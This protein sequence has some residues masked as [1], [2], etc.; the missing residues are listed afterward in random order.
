[1]QRS[2]HS[3]SL[4]EKALNNR[5]K[6]LE[7]FDKIQYFQEFNASQLADLIHQHRAS[8]SQGEKFAKELVKRIAKNIAE[9]DLEKLAKICHIVS[10]YDVNQELNTSLLISLFNNEKIC[11][12]L[13][14]EIIARTNCRILFRIHVFITRL[15]Q[16]DR[17]IQWLTQIAEL[18]SDVCQILIENFDFVENCDQISSLII[19]YIIENQQLELLDS[20]AITQEH[21]NSI[22]TFKL[23]EQLSCEATTIELLFHE[24]I[25]AGFTIELDQEYGQH[26][27]RKSSCK[28]LL[29][30]FIN[31]PKF[32]ELLIA[33]LNSLG[34]DHSLAAIIPE[35]YFALANLEEHRPDFLEQVVNKTST[36]VDVFKNNHCIERIEP[37][38]ISAIIKH[39][40]HDLEFIAKVLTDRD[41]AV[42][43][44]ELVFNTLLDEVNKRE[45]L[46]N[47]AYD[48]QLT[49]VLLSDPMYFNLLEPLE[50]SDLLLKNIKYL[51]RTLLSSATT[52]EGEFSFENSM[53]DILRNLQVRFN[54]PPEQRLFLLLALV[55]PELASIISKQKPL[56]Y[57]NL[58]HSDVSEILAKYADNYELQQEFFENYLENNSANL[59]PTAL[60]FITK[61]SALL[62]EWLQHKAI[63]DFFNST[64]SKVYNSAYYLLRINSAFKS[65]P[66]LQQLIL[67][68]HKHNC[69][70][71]GILENLIEIKEQDELS[72]YIELLAKLNLD[73]RKLASF[74]FNLAMNIFKE[75]KLYSLLDLEQMVHL[76]LQYQDNERFSLLVLRIFTAIKIMHKISLN[77]L[78][79]NET[80]PSLNQFVD[81]QHQQAAKSI[82]DLLS[83]EARFHL[84]SQKMVLL[85]SAKYD[86]E[87]AKLTFANND[88]FKQL[89][90]LDILKI[91]FAHMNTPQFTDLRRHLSG[92]NLSVRTLAKANE[93]TAN[94]I[95]QRE[96]TDLRR[97]FFTNQEQL[98]ELY[99]SQGKDF[100]LKYRSARY[101]A[102]NLLTEAERLN[103]CI[104]SIIKFQHSGI[105]KVELIDILLDMH[106]DTLQVALTN[107]GMAKIILDNFD[108]FVKENLVNT[109]DFEN[110]AR[111]H[112]DELA[113]KYIKKS[114]WQSFSVADYI[115]ERLSATWNDLGFRAGNTVSSI[116]DEVSSLSFATPVSAADLNFIHNYDSF[117]NSKPEVQIR[118]IIKF[119]NEGN[120]LTFFGYYA[121]LLRPRIKQYLINDRE[122]AK[123]LF[124]ECKLLTDWVD[125]N[126]HPFLLQSD[127]IEIAERHGPEFIRHHLATIIYPSNDDLNRTNQPDQAIIDSFL[128]KLKTTV[129]FSGDEIIDDVICYR[130][131]RVF[132]KEYFKFLAAVDRP[133]GK[134]ILRVN[135]FGRSSQYLHSIRKFFNM[136]N[137]HFPLEFLG[138]ELIDVLIENPD[139]ILENYREIV[140]KAAANSTLVAMRLARNERD[141][142]CLQNY[143]FTNPTPENIKILDNMNEHVVDLICN[144]SAEFIRQHWYTVYKLAFANPLV[145]KQLTQ[146]N[147]L[148]QPIHD[149][150]LRMAKSTPDGIS[151]LNSM[152]LETI[153]LVKQRDL[154][155]VQANL[156]LFYKQSLRSKYIAKTFA[157]QLPQLLPLQNKIIE[158]IARYAIGHDASLKEQYDILKHC[159]TEMTL[160]H[161]QEFISSHWETIIKVA[162]F[163]EEIALNFFFPVKP[164]NRMPAQKKANIEFMSNYLIKRNNHQLTAEK[165]TIISYLE[166]Y[167]KRADNTVS[168][169]LMRA[170]AKLK[171][172]LA[173]MNTDTNDCTAVEVMPS[174]FGSVCLMTLGLDS[175]PLRQQLQYIR[176][177][178]NKL[179]DDFCIA[180][181]KTIQADLN[182]DEIADLCLRM[183]SHLITNMQDLLAA[184]TTIELGHV[185]S[186][187]SETLKYFSIT[188]SKH[189]TL[190]ERF[191]EEVLLAVRN[192]SEIC[193]DDTLVEVP[194]PTS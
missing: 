6:A 79:L 83:G 34:A 171:L 9:I 185:Q 168:S 142:I 30:K 51:D 54:L 49:L 193:I 28:L 59:L 138:Q 165:I 43:T 63:R 121:V 146:Q 181:L 17:G 25:L 161:K 147:P 188:E 157:L 89:S 46:N 42:N 36:A 33:K 148:L 170:N 176:G 8:Y 62:I 163:D 159:F 139:L 115:P 7:I 156:E 177:L 11:Q 80:I 173:Q 129:Q 113:D 106:L 69:Q 35:L 75:E 97:I 132:I 172:L 85:E 65:D 78:I 38:N 189:A 26:R 128:K 40:N 87:I 37:E 24:K 119:Q 143:L 124:T 58:R 10:T 126:G 32:F 53:Q 153:N 175:E 131:N 1:M 104:N 22:F 152:E 52:A 61:D 145:A 74:D 29:E 105:S 95:M 186:I 92:L 174:E 144:R 184:Q 180:I 137:L 190:E 68:E 164:E 162:A 141:L 151:V 154:G 73:I 88:F 158:T 19:K 101:H 109:Q 90:A 82:W 55:N 183:R 123:L 110:I 120:F 4:Y 20:P 116:K 23:F 86:P 64:N 57:F 44:R 194:I 5:K 133:F 98:N 103:V 114:F 99:L 70:N 93:E 2:N 136:D 155:F 150:I 45:F 72:D 81:S 107:I 76:L 77:E 41:I 108:F 91:L 50:I 71:S 111:A 14:Q 134:L 96:I 122:L 166:K 149:Q 160:T 66:E 125:I 169:N 67:T 178:S 182:Q 100:I 191:A 112:G 48:V 179:I 27:L 118:Q 192:L 16:H 135:K 21:I 15:L 130:Q 18:D 39:F 60:S 3:D 47:L 94:Y 167:I 12:A 13:Q 127:K 140:L 187:I 31:K 117:R 102:I 56:S 84:T